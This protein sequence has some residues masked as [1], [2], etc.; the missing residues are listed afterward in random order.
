MQRIKVKSRE[1]IA[2]ILFDCMLLTHMVQTANNFNAKFDYL[3]P[4]EHSIYFYH[5]VDEVESLAT[6][7]E[8]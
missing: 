8:K 1:I 5:I 2:G 6:V 7:R 3:T 4:F